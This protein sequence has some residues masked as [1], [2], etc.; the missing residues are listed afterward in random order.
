MRRGFFICLNQ[1]KMTPYLIAWWCLNL[2]FA[3]ILSDV[4]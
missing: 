2:K 4:M 1:I 3:Y